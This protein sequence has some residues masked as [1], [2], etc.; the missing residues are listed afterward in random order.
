MGIADD[1]EKLERLHES[2]A[3][4]D[5]EFDDAKQH[6]LN[7]YDAY[8]SPDPDDPADFGDDDDS[9]GVAANRYVTYQIIAG[10]VGLVVFL[11]LLVTVFLP[12]MHMV[13]HLTIP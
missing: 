4:S 10:V 8:D 9:I 1:L 11:I 2:G 13:S 5:R 6:V 7:S 12:M 3:L